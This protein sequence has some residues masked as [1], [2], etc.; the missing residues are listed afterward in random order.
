[1]RP[2]PIRPSFLLPLLLV[3][4]LCC[5]CQRPAIQST[6]APFPYQE[7]DIA[8][9]QARM[10]AGELDSVTLTDAYLRRIAELDRSGPTLR[11]VTELNPAA[12]REA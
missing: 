3:L 5:A 12:R 6:E 10:A 11:A 7:A 9:L 4:A 8:G 1:M 2:F